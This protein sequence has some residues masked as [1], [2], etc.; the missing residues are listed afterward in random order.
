M[1][2]Q[3]MNWN[4]WAADIELA[5]IEGPNGLARV[6]EGFD[7]AVED[8]RVIVRIPQADGSYSHS[9]I[10]YSVDFGGERESFTS[11]GEAYIAAGRK[12]GRP[13]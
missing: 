12:A 10:V 6:L 7:Y 2:Q 5:R 9:R 3:G 4:E 8:S 11:L 1:I 13:V